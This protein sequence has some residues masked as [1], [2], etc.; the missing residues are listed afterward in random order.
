MSEPLTLE[1]KDQL[2]AITPKFSVS[3]ISLNRVKLPNK[4]LD[5][6]PSWSDGY[7]HRGR[8]NKK[9]G[10]LCQ[11]DSLFLWMQSNWILRKVM[12]NRSNDRLLIIYRGQIT[13]NSRKSK[14][15]KYCRDILMF[16]FY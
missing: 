1:L 3:E 15:L 9:P 13:P 11:A 7:E 8:L 4:P 16:E 2:F 6:F 14:P 10:T 12:I 5:I